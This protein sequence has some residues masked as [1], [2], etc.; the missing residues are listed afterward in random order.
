[1]RVTYPAM[2]IL[3]ILRRVVP[4]VLAV[5]L[6]LLVVSGGAFVLVTR[7]SFPQTTGTLKLDGLTGKVDVIR[8]KFG[9]PHIYADTPEDLFRAQGFVHAQ[10]RYFQM[11]FSR[12]IG[13]GRLS[14][15]F[16]ASALNQDKFI[17]TI[18]WARTAQEEA[19]NMAP[20]LKRYM[21][22][23]AAGVNGYIL[24]NADKLGFEFK[25]LGLIGRTFKPEP[26]APVNSLTWGKAMAYNLGGNMD[27]E[28]L[29]AALLA[30]GGRQLADTLMPPYPRDMPVIAPS[31][32]SSDSGAPAEAYI[33]EE[34]LAGDLALEMLAAKTEV[35]GLIGLNHESDIGS[36]NWVIGGARTTT[37]KPILANDPHLAIQM[38]S[39]WYQV[40][41]HCRVVSATCPFDVAGVSF[42]GVPGVVIGHN[43]RIAWGVTNVGPDTQ[44]YYI[45]RPNPANPDEFEFKGA[46]EK[47]RIV[48]EVINVGGGQPVNIKVRITRHGPIMS[49]VVSDLKTAYQQPVSLQWTSLTPG[50]L[51][52]AVFGLNKAQS[53]LDFRVALR[54]WDSPSQNFVYADV[55]GNI[56]YQMPGRIPIRASGDGEAPTPGW[57]GDTEW[58]GFIPFDDLPSVFNPPEGYIVTA[59]NAVVDAS[60]YKRFIAKDWD[61]GFRARQI[62]SLVLAKDKHSVDDIRQMQFD[63]TSGLAND[64]IPYVANISVRDDALISSALD[65]LK[66]WDRR[67]TR[68]QVGP[69]IFETFWIQLGHNIFDDE[70]GPELAQDAVNTGTATKTAVRQALADPSSRFWDDVTTG[71]VTETREQLILKAFRETVVKLKA[72]YGDDVKKWTWGTPHTVTFK[73]QTLGQSGTAPIESIF[74]RGPFPADGAS[75][76]VNNLGG[77]GTTY[78]VSSG[79]S[80][81]LVADL[82]DFSK[83]LL[84]HTTGQS[85]HTYNPHYDDMIG[86]YLAGQNNP[87]LWTRADVDKNAEASLTLTP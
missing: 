38:P 49:D 64:V 15:L 2:K 19:A 37:G 62:T 79:P 23:Y 56:G 61:Y 83:S 46:F 18:G 31:A 80:L 82:S 70:L 33:F 24:P 87:M 47:A 67:S 26:W 7:S 44:D 12:R 81:R 3:G 72:Q 41:L 76:A 21:E 36:N 14:E 55:D 53:W 63:V 75:G 65:A 50:S 1:M 86:P 11:E 8:D 68:D 20:E 32:A 57:T 17:R 4:I 42:A 13:Q 30:K 52:A 25:V 9:V 58:T 84:I 34:T 78:R 85:G 39:I 22:A 35:M 66:A 40:G 10:D 6:V 27:D 71:G 54:D 60:K 16:G 29:R 59:N 43:A 77:G 28:L 48:D 69:L 5:L 73:N 51:V 45:E 74:N